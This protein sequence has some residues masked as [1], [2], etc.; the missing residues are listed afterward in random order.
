MSLS[1]ISPEFKHMTGIPK[2][3]T[4]NGEDVSPPLR[5]S[6]V[7]AGTKSLALIVNYTG[8]TSPLV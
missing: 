1:L 8:A 2:R 4:C 7:P 3:F 5:W 6:G